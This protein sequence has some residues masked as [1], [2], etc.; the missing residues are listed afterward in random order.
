[1]CLHGKRSQFT[2][3]IYSIIKCHTYTVCMYEHACAILSHDNVSARIT[4]PILNPYMPILA[5]IFQVSPIASSPAL[6]DQTKYPNFARLV[7]S[8]VV[9][10]DGIM[11]LMK[12]YGWSR[13]AA[14]TQQEFLFTKVQ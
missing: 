5:F 6:S 3:V 14:I 12:Q 2:A 9:V 8:D 4:S 1:M 11:A 7:T 10:A 13:V